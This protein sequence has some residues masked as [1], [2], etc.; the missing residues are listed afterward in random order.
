MQIVGPVRRKNIISLTPLIDVVFILLIFFML[1]TSFSRYG[2]YSIQTSEPADSTSVDSEKSVLIEI[3]ESGM[4]SIDSKVH[5]AIDL[6]QRLQTASQ[7]DIGTTVI[8]KP[9]KEVPIQ[10]VVGIL[11]VLA[12]LEMINITI[13]R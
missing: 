12:E 11:D 5:S 13:I 6:R 9:A 8:I 1:A 7:V 4:I 2:S 3:S 10:K